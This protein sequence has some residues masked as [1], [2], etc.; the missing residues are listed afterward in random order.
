VEQ[1]KKQEKKL[2][3]ECSN[4]EF[5]SNDLYHKLI[6]FTDYPVITRQKSGFF[7]KNDENH[8]PERT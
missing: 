3:L 2:K 4:P 7:A 6:I 8:Y 5:G 1:V